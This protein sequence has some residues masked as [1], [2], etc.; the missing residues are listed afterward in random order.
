MSGRRRTS[1]RPCSSP[2]SDGLLKFSQLIAADLVAFEHKQT[3][4]GYVAASGWRVYLT[5][6]GNRIIDAWFS[7]SR[8]DVREALSPPPSEASP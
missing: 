1:Y 6:R 2:S 4:Y 5:A 7:G 3:Q 8:I